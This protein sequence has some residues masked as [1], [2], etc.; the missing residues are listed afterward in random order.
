MLLATNWLIQKMVS[1]LLE[2]SFSPKFD[3]VALLIL[4]Y[5]LFLLIIIVVTI[6]T[7][8]VFYIVSHLPIFIG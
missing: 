2:F 5:Y 1:D 4:G 6:E 3:S 8:R 7:I